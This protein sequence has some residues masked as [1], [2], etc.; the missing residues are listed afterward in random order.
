MI[1]NRWP[2]AFVHHLH[3]VTLKKVTQTFPRRCFPRK[4]SMINSCWCNNWTA[5]CCLW[6]VSVYLW[7]CHMYLCSSIS[8]RQ[9]DQ[10]HDWTPCWSI[11]RA[12][13]APP[14]Q[15]ETIRRGKPEQ[16]VIPEGKRSV[17]TLMLCQSIT[18]RTFF[19]KNMHRGACSN[20]CTSTCTGKCTSSTGAE[21]STLTMAQI[22]MLKPK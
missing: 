7:L 9:N 10:H 3:K 13:N 17:I 8:L 19:K 20:I 1:H 16:K 4:M 18:C 15:W 2:F 21:Y 5:C 14:P 11:T 12:T 22:F 6:R